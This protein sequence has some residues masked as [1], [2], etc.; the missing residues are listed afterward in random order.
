MVD[1]KTKTTV[2]HLLEADKFPI[3]YDVRDNVTDPSGFSI[4]GYDIAAFC[5][6]TKV[7]VEMQIYSCNFQTKSNETGALGY[8]FCPVG[9][10]KLE[11][12]KLD[13]R[14]AAEGGR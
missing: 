1:N 10:Y 3:T 13:N 2:L 9:V 11:N 7:A 8:S 4:P 14:E 12:V 5:A 6:N